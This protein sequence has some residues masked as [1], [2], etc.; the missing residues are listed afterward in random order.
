VADLAGMP[1]RIGARRALRGKIAVQHADPA[2]DL[3]ATQR[4]EPDRSSSL[5]LFSSS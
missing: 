3:V 1:F 4:V 5:M 2:P